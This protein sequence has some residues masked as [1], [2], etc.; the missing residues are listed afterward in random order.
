MNLHVSL[1]FVVAAE[2]PFAVSKQALRKHNYMKYNYDI[3]FCCYQQTLQVLHYIW[4][5]EPASDCNLSL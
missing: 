1:Q 5:C 3:M 4:Q 2:S